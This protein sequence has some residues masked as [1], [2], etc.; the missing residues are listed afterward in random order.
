MHREG[1]VDSVTEG[2]SFLSGHK[3]SHAHSVTVTVININHGCAMVCFEKYI[4]IIGLPGFFT[5]SIV[6]LKVSLVELS[7][8]ITSSILQSSF[9]N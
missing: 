9:L 8:E 6:I 1:T 7:P 5:E 3:N 2:T 4:I